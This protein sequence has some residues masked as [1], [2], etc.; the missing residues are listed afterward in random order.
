MPPVLWVDVPFEVPVVV[1]VGAVPV[2]VVGEAGVVEVPLEDGLPV[3]CEGWLLS[4]SWLITGLPAIGSSGGSLLAQTLIARRTNRGSLAMLCV[5]SYG[6]SLRISSLSRLRERS[7]P[8][9]A[10]WAYVQRQ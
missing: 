4:G 7:A 3:G 8:A 9:F 5:R 2:G 1:L 6:L 10:R